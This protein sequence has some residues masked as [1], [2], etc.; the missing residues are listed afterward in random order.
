MIAKVCVA[1]R[2][3]VAAD[4]LRTALANIHDIVAS[5]SSTLW[6][7]VVDFCHTVVAMVECE[8]TT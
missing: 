8:V 2:S 6:V 1:T 4:V 3:L 5:M 7:C